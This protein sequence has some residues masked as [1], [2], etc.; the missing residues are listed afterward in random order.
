MIQDKNKIRRKMHIKIINVTYNVKLTQI[1][2]KKINKYSYPL[3]V[4][5]LER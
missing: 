1:Y 3:D 2:L 5:L 4:S